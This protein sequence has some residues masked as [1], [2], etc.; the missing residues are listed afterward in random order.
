[1]ATVRLDIAYDGSGFSGWA[2][3]PGLRTVQGELESALAT[4]LREQ[5]SLTVAGRTD[6]GVHAW[7]QVASFEASAPPSPGLG[8]R[9][10]GVGPPDL[11]VTAASVAADGFDARRDAR[12]RTYC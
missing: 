5:V 7:G 12:S 3:Q 2:A 8:G 10:N 1:M 11:A 9:L 6:A 4:V